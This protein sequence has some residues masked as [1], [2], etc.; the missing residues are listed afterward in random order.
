MKK[1]RNNDMPRFINMNNLTIHFGE[2]ETEVTG[3]FYPGYPSFGMDPP[4]YPEAAWDFIND[5]DNAW[6]NNLSTKEQGAFYE[7][8]VLAF[9]EYSEEDFDEPD[10]EPDYERDL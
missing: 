10:Y 4:E 8:V 9:E 5:E 7:K 3:V 1:E 6:Y 2:K